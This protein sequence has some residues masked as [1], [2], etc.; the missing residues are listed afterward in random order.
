MT[1]HGPSPTELLGQDHRIIEKVL[2]ELEAISR[3]MARGGKVP[4]EALTDAIEFSQTFVDA[5][6]HG[7]EESCLFP[8]LE[9]RGIP[10]DGPIGVMLHEHQVGREYVKRIQE[11]MKKHDELGYGGT[12][13]R[14]IG[15]YAA[16]L[17][18]HIFKEENILF[19]MGD[20]VMREEDQAETSECFERSE[21]EK[22]GKEKHDQMVKLADSLGSGDQHAEFRG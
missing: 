14:L 2:S 6:H 3:Q 11:E 9:K 15:E 10:R 8:C 5:C 19:R 21:E 12:L 22:V 13:P 18:Q 20:Q 17:R 1:E 16:H 7:K 4:A